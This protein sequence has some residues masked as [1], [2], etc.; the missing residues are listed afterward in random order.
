MPSTDRSRTS[1]RLH[2]SEWMRRRNVESTRTGER[3]ETQGHAGRSK[4]MQ[5]IRNVCRALE[6][7][8][9]HSKRMA[10]YVCTLPCTRR[11]TAVQPECRAA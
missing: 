11:L 7:Y 5:R 8:V 2:V 10:N 4:R 3:K 6:T 1:V 9:G